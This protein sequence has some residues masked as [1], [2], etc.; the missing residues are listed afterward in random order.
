M[1]AKIAGLTSQAVLDLSY[2]ILTDIINYSG[3]IKLK[4]NAA[5]LLLLSS[6]MR[7]AKDV[8]L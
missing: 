4:I 2:E 6:R 7:F 5:V 1:I 3:K 8:A